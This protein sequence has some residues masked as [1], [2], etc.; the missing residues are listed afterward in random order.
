MY[1]PE[2]TKESRELKLE[3]AKQRCWFVFLLEWIKIK[4]FKRGKIVVEQS[5]IEYTEESKFT[6][7]GDIFEEAKMRW[8]NADEKGKELILR[9]HRENKSV[10]AKDDGLDPSKI[11]EVKREGFFQ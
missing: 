4:I 11:I 5:D 2:V 1:L 9:E 8:D 3:E 6:T 7:F 10:R